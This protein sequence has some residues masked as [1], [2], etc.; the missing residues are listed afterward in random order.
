VA[1][2]FFESAAF[3]LPSP[4]HDE[5]EGTVCQPSFNKHVD[6]RRFGNQFSGATVIP[7]LSRPKYAPHHEKL[8]FAMI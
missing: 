3:A 5:K 4:R 1:D 6:V 2:L 8:L 7:A